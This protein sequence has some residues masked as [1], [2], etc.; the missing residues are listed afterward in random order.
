LKKTMRAAERFGVK[1]ILTAGGVAANQYLRNMLEKE[2]QKRGF[3]VYYPSLKL[4]TDNAAMIAGKA[5]LSYVRGDF[6]GLS[7]NA[8]PGL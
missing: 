4:C 8:Y 3:S 2:G 5:Y 7:L 6:A 1:S